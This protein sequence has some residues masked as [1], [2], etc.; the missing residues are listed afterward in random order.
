[1]AGRRHRGRGVAPAPRRHRSPAATL[2][3]IWWLL[4]TA[5]LAGILLWA[6]A[7]VLIFLA[8][9][10]GALGVVAALMIALARALRA[11]GGRRENAP[12]ATAENSGEGD[13]RC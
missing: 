1:V 6:F 11:W 13:R 10:A 3:R 4:A 7:P 2:L 8:L 12:R 9:L 5:L